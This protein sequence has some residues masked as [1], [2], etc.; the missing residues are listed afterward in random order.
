MY[1]H[2]RGKNYL[3]V[4]DVA[5]SVWKWAVNIDEATTLSGE[6]KTRSGALAT[7]VLTIDRSLTRHRTAASL[8][9]SI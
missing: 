1:K 2:Y 5:S 6:D 8:A 4:Q 9:I 7:V 3:V